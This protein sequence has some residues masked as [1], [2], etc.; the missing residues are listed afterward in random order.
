[1]GVLL[2]VSLLSCGAARKRLQGE[3]SEY[4]CVTETK[5]TLNETEV[6]SF[7]PADWFDLLLN[8]FDQYSK[9]PDKKPK[10]CTKAPLKWPDHKSCK[11]KETDSL[12]LERTAVSEKDLVFS[13]LTKSKRL[14]WGI[15]H[16]YEN[17]EALGSVAISEFT[18]NGV[19]VHAIGAL[20]APGQRVRMELK[21]TDEGEVLLVEGQLCAEDSEAACPRYV[22]AMQLRGK[23]FIPVPLRNKVGDCLSPAYFPLE[24]ELALKMDDGGVR[25]YSMTSSIKVNRKGVVVHEKLTVH[26]SD[27]SQP[28]SVPRLRRQAEIDRQI[29]VVRGR[30]IPESQSLWHRVEVDTGTGAA[31]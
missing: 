19:V 3:N 22:R 21:Q 6:R 15:T 25:K 29:R 16:R 4:V 20:R 1:M 2:G 31:K 11:V 24:R 14:V 9:I 27:P 17:G 5:T 13:Q 7:W 8:N 18:P 30:F 26:D 23:R 10:L 12:R 28:E